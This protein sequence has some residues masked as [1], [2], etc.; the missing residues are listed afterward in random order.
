MHRI[1]RFYARRASVLAA[2]ATLTAGLVLTG[3]PAQ[4][5]PPT[6][7]DASTARSMLA[8]LTVAPEGS[9]TGYDRDK[10]PHW[11]SQGDNCNTREV[12]LER[13]GSGVHTGSDCYPTSGSWYS[14]YD[15]ET[16][17]QPSDLDIDHIVPLA[18]AWRSG[19][20]DWTTSE[21]EQ[22]ANDLSISQLIAVTDN[23]NQSKGDDDPASWLPPRSA[24]HCTYAREY[25]WVKYSYDMTVDSAEHTAL[26]NVLSGC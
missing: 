1:R 2:L 25:V 22:L 13:D 12:V 8:S 26:S 19:A 14:E 20:A 16:W 7:P 15:G 17:T 3:G 5:S 11:S 10:F 23:V 4:A 6:P 9:M 18:E 24:Y 21:R